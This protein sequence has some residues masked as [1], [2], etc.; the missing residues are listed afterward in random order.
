[1]AALY[2]DVPAKCE[3]VKGTDVLKSGREQ[4]AVLDDFGAVFTWGARRVQ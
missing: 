1:M 4:L 3:V 2:T